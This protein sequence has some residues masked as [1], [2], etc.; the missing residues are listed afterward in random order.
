MTLSR[1]KFLV[2]ASS[3]AAVATTPVLSLSRPQF[4]TRKLSLYNIHSKNSFEGEYWREGQYNETALE[5]LSLLLK[6]RRN[7]KVHPM[8]PQL[9]DLLH[10]LQETLGV[11]NPYHVICGYRSKETNA[12]LCKESSGV[13]KKSLHMVGKAIDL[14]L[15]S[16][17]LKELRDAAKS[18][19]GG[20]VG[21]YP[22]S[23]FVHLD[24]SVLLKLLFGDSTQVSWNITKGRF[25]YMLE[26]H[27]NSIFFHFWSFEDHLE[28]YFFFHRTIILII[29]L[30]FFETNFTWLSSLSLY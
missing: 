10:K 29:K 19:K 1:R 6:D 24:V 2:L 5:Q 4:S 11:Q 26:G 13:A 30:Y 18:L 28:E 7:Q 16:T 14:R 12:M 23:N 15:E 25:P 21:Y 20:G 22:K 27:Y 8:D 17:P 9:F 3:F